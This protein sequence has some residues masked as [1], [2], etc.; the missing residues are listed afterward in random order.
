[1]Y[2]PKTSWYQY[3][4]ILRTYRELL[5]YNKELKQALACL[6]K[7]MREGYSYVYN[8]FKQVMQDY[9]N[10]KGIFTRNWQ[11]KHFPEYGEQ[12]IRK[13]VDE[14]LIGLEDTK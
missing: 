5:L 4:Y 11:E 8:D 9:F 7:D 13:L 12:E 3:N 6:H 2:G 14:Y 10:Y 1:M